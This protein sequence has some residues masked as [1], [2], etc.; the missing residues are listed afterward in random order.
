MQY[1]GVEM[2]GYRAKQPVLMV[3]VIQ[4]SM[5]SLLAKWGKSVHKSSYSMTLSIPYL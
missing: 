5:K 3:L 2:G 1:T 4:S